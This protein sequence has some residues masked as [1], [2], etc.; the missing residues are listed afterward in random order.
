MRSRNC[1][2]NFGD[3]PPTIHH[4]LM[5]NLIDNDALFQRSHEIFS[6]H[7]FLPAVYSKYLVAIRTYPPSSVPRTETEWILYLPDVSAEVSTS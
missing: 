2:H 3:L 7:V 4:E 6:P 5:A 1:L